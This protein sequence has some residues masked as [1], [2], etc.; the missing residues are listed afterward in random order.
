MS[1]RPRRWYAWQGWTNCNFCNKRILDSH[2][3][4]Y[5]HENGDFTYCKECRDKYK[6][7]IDKFLND[8]IK[9]KDLTPYL[10]DDDDLVREL[11]KQTYER[12]YEKSLYGWRSL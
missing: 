10:M 9:I 6:E 1:A 5:L 7:T 2:S 3:Y 12:Q 4:Q 8:K 11:A